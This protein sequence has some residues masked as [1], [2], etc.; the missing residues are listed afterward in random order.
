M[1]GWKIRRSVLC[2]SVIS[3]HQNQSP[4]VIMLATIKRGKGGDVKW[5]EGGEREGE[6][7]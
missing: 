2:A 1:Q 6:Q 7:N 4:A 3:S 5:Q